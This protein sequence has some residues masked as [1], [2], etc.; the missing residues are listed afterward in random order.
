[1]LLRLLLL[2]QQNIKNKSHH[3][4]SFGSFTL[5]ASDWQSV[6]LSSHASPLLLVLLLSH[7]LPSLPLP[8]ALSLHCTFMCRILSRQRRVWWRGNA[9][10]DVT[11]VETGEEG[12]KERA[13]GRERERDTPP[14][15]VLKH[16]HAAVT[17]NRG[18]RVCV[19]V[20]LVLSSCRGQFVIEH[21]PRG[22]IFLGRTTWF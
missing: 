8:L 9:R 11:V 2:L 13:S 7:L 22:D 16:K 12:G 3:G 19:C 14:F 6:D 21:Q 1:M 17:R 10:Q 15:L 20:V 18:V 5:L 4:S